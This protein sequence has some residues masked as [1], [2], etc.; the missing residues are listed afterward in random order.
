RGEKEKY[1]EGPVPDAFVLGRGDLLVVMTDLTQNAPILG[2]AAF[3]PESERYLHNQ[4]LGKVVQL[5]DEVDVRFLYYVLNAPSVRA[6][7]RSTATGSTVRHTS[8]D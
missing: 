5:S 7:I 3:V 2:S 1:Y 6:Q 8:P 4:R